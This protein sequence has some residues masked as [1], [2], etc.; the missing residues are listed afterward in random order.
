MLRVSFFVSIGLHVLLFS[1]VSVFVSPQ[2]Q[3]ITLSEQRFRVELRKQRIAANSGQTETPLARAPRK[4]IPQRPLESQH[5]ASSP[6]SA[7]QKRQ[8]QSAQAPQLR[9]PEQTPRIIPKQAE[10]KPLQRER[11][12]VIESQDFLVQAQTFPTP[13]P[14]PKP[15]PAPT[16]KPTPIPRPKPTPVP[17]AKPT[18]RPTAR[19]TPIPTQQPTIKPTA[20]PTTMI[21]RHTTEKSVAAPAT[22]TPMPASSGS[23]AQENEQSSQEQRNHQQNSQQG[24]EK[25]KS[26]AQP[27][28]G[29]LQGYLQQ[30]VKKINAHKTYPRQARKKGWQGT[31]VVK[32]RILSDG[33]LAQLEL[34]TPSDYDTLNKAALESINKA[35]PFPKFPDEMGSRTLTIN[36]PIQF[37][38]K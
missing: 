36:I 16:A 9:F 3:R 27:D 1:L 26:Q 23:H 14:T 24:Q 30:V 21:A 10:L 28:P 20:I 29:V 5:E 22:V 32:V 19:P 37:T 8:Q 4:M 25:Q 34:E 6:L 35:Q 13:V 2:E 7:T 12:P 11:K 31:V 38:L 33:V 18:S 15:T 17:T